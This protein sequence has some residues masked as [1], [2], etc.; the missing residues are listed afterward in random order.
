M[1]K[2][3]EVGMVHSS[4]F[5]SFFSFLLSSKF[6]NK[7]FLPSKFWNKFQNKLERP[8]DFHSCG[9]VSVSTAYLKQL[10]CFP[11]IVPLAATNVIQGVTVI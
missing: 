11:E 10:S 5:A 1:G 9:L 3:L 2:C 4:T 8:H 6:Q 7:C